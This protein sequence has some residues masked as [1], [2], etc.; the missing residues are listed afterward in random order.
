MALGDQR[1]R[2]SWVP[3]SRCAGPGGGGAPS[4]G[5]Q[6]LGTARLEPQAMS[7]ASG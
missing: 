3:G 6:G 1:S 7:Q 2:S 5:L 4:T